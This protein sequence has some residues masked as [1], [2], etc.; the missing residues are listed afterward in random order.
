MI[1]Y[2]NSRILLSF[3]SLVAAS[4]AFGAP[5]DIVVEMSNGSDSYKADLSK[6]TR[7]TFRGSSMIIKAAG[8]PDVSIPVR[9]IHRIVFDLA[10]SSVE[11]IEAVL[12]DDLT[13]IVEHKKVRV[14]SASGGNVELHIFD[15]SGRLADVVTGI[16]EAEYDFSDKDTGVYI[17]TSSGKN[18]KYLNK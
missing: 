6:N 9:D 14:I 10:T 12:T 1:K 7:I 3:A 4:V 11:E 15:A 17:V 2:P 18:I 8:E 5:D 16:R 13:F